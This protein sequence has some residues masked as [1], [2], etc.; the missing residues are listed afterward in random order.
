M[1]ECC[2]LAFQGSVLTQALLILSEGLIVVSCKLLSRYAYVQ[3]LY[4]SVLMY[5]VRLLPVNDLVCI[6]FYRCLRK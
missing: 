4:V 1:F 2:S 6:M 3:L 5:M